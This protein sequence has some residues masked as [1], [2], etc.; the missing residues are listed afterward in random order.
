M[1]RTILNLLRTLAY[2][3]I[4]GLVGYYNYQTSGWVGAVTN[5]LFLVIG[6]M[7]ADVWLNPRSKSE[8]ISAGPSSSGIGTVAPVATNQEGTGKE[9]TITASSTE[10]DE[11]E[12]SSN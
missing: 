11:T 3:A 2:L 4:C 12:N 9:V 1:K 7:L 6:I 10:T 8:Q 5:A